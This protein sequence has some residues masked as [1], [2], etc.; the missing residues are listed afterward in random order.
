MFHYAIYQSH[1]PLSSLLLPSLFV[2]PRDN[3]C[4]SCYKMYLTFQRTPATL[5]RAT[6]LLGEERRE[7]GIDFTFL[8]FTIISSSS[9]KS[10]TALRL[11]KISSGH[12]PS[13]WSISSPVIAADPSSPESSSLYSDSP[14]P[15][16][17]PSSEARWHLQGGNH[18][19]Q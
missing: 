17:L 16:K 6:W 11:I 15:V 10:I 8:A 3:R 4:R 1:N 5:L 19:R 7:P 9:L 12:S 2:Y 14:E 18:Q 13:A